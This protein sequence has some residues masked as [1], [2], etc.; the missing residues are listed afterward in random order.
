[1]DEYTCVV[2]SDGVPKEE[3]DKMDKEFQAYPAHK[4]CFDEFDNA[5]EFL[6][7]CKGR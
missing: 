2:C 1:M 5:D 4:E 6:T 7:Y 3:Y